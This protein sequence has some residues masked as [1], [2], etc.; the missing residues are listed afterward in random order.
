MGFTGL[1]FIKWR[2]IFSF[3]LF[4][5]VGIG[6]WRLLMMEWERRR[7][8]VESWGGGGKLEEVGGGMGV[9]AGS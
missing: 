9:L 3:G 7:R 4:Y 2:G 1:L 8:I 6:Y 5:L